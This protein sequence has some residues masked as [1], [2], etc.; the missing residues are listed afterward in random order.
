M[1]TKKW[2]DLDVRGLFHHTYAQVQQDG[3]VV[4]RAVFWDTTVKP[5]NE[6]FLVIQAT[7]AQPETYEALV[8]EDE[9]PVSERGAELRTFIELLQHHFCY[10]YLISDGVAMLNETL[11]GDSGT[12]DS[13]VDERWGYWTFGADL[14]EIHDNR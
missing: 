7:G 6:P 1:T 14:E 13:P 12:S 11:S 3:S 2:F 4:Y 9:V 8:E 5:G 10:K